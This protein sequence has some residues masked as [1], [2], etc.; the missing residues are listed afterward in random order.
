MRDEIK[1]HSRRHFIRT[2]FSGLAGAALA[3]SVFKM[4]GKFPDPQKKDT[5]FIYRTL[6]KTG[7]E[8]PI[9]SMGTYD[10]L[11]VVNAALDAGVKHIDTSADYNEGND[12]RMFGEVFK[13]RTRDSFVI[14]TSIGMWQYRDADQIK[15]AVSPGLVHTR[16]TG[17]VSST[18]LRRSTSHGLSRVR[19]TALLPPG[20]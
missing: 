10:A 7:I 13:N 12:E 19:E 9:V 1:D 3:P 18:R 20:L 2:G 16:P 14:G 15:N 6:G 8:L 4:D 11:G 5:K 17:P